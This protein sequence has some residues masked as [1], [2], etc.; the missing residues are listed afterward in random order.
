MMKT[1]GVFL[2]VGGLILSQAFCQKKPPQNTDSSSKTI[3]RVFQSSDHNTV[4]LYQLRAT[5]ASIA[6]MLFSCWYQSKKQTDES[7][8]LWE[9]LES[10]QTLHQFPINSRISTGYLVDEYLRQKGE[11]KNKL[12]ASILSTLFVTSLLPLGL[13]SGGSIV[14]FFSQMGALIGA[15]A[16]I[17]KETSDNL[18]EFRRIEDDLKRLHEKELYEIMSLPLA[19]RLESINKSITASLAATAEQFQ[20]SPKVLPTPI[21]EYVDATLRVL[22]SSN[23]K[24]LASSE[25]A[26]LQHP[27]LFD[28]PELLVDYEE[29]QGEVWKIRPNP[30]CP[31]PQEVVQIEKRRLATDI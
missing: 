23:A 4:W 14:V 8:G 21:Q 5:S 20:K 28:R 17:N 19:T 24:E 22:R 16:T 13:T 3:T 27:L 7:V 25:A 26:H 31:S 18:P 6:G 9:V 1:L 29:G 2:G 30:G 15:L 12:F 10:S 11:Y